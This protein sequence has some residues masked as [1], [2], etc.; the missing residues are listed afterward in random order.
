[1]ELTNSA[2][3]YIDRSFALGGFNSSPKDKLLSEKFQGVYQG[4]KEAAS[5]V[6]DII[7]DLRDD[8]DSEAKFATS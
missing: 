1:M 6:L 2:T 4:K 8:L 3:E 5:Q 7:N